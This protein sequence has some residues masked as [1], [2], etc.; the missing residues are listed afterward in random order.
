MT[1]QLPEISK[2]TKKRKKN[3]A[4]TKVWLFNQKDD[5]KGPKD[6]PKLE[7]IINDFLIDNEIENNEFTM[8][9]WEFGEGY[10]I[11]TLLYTKK[12]SLPP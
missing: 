11:V 2:H 5:F 12:F 1:A 7:K 9:E 4:Q 3:I 8:L 10:I 6:L